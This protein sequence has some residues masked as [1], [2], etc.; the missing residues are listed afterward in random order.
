MSQLSSIIASLQI[1][2]SSLEK[3]EE[4]VKA[5]ITEGNQHKQSSW[6]GHMTPAVESPALL[7][8]LVAGL[9]NGNL[10]S[11]DL[12]PQLTQIESQL[13][14][15]LCQTFKQ[16]YGHFT[17]GSS[18]A[19][20]EALWQAREHSQ[21]TSNIVYASTA[22]HYSIA[23]ACQILGLKLQ[24]IETNEQGQIQ[25]DALRKA[26]QKTKPI[27]IIATAGTTSC[28]AIDPLSECID[29]A[30]E[31]NSW[32]HIDAAWG[33]AL[34]LLDEHSDLFSIDADSLCFDP[35]KSL[36]QPK[37]CS[38]LLYQRPLAPF[39][40][41]E[42]DY[43]TTAPTQTLVGSHGGELFL[44]LWYSL[45][46][47]KEGLINQLRQRLA[48]AEQ[49]AALL[50]EKTKWTVWHS[51]TGIVCFKVPNEIDLLPLE[52]QG[53]LSHAKINGEKVY[54]TI[55]ANSNTKTEDIWTEITPYL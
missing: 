11:A 24:T 53:W 22:V 38:I 51:V 44:P 40:D 4:L 30:H 39:L 33:G 27:A 36:G 29:I 28:G 41:I 1:A 35:H 34:A 37:P 31:V 3:D 6:A 17:H 15:W 8:Q 49:F 5:L 50:Q 55:F 7:G 21:N 46:L 13:I 9:H 26:C 32:C 48:Q 18:Y 2:L 47:D 10:L 19:N 54:R 12:Y 25:V 42:T 16:Q 23:K 14:D 45:L 52:K 43:L 20:L